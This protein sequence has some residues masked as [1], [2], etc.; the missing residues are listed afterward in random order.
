MQEITN[1][2]W[3]DP[4]CITTGRGPVMAR[5]SEPNDQFWTLWREHS[6]ALRNAGFSIG[7]FAGK[8]K[9]T[10]WE[11]DG[12]FNLP[13]IAAPVA[14]EVPELVLSPLKYPDG[15]LPYQLP[16]TQIIV[17][18][19]EEFNTALNASST[20]TGKTFMTLGAIRE[21]GRRALIICPKAIVGDWKDACKRMGVECAG[22][23]G[24]EWMK[25]GKTP[26]AK[27]TYKRVKKKVGKEFVLVDQKDQ[28]VWDVPDDCDLV[29][30]ECHRAANA[31]TIN[32]Q[33]VQDAVAAGYK[34][35]L[36]SATVADNPTK[37]KA[38]G[39]ALRLHKNSK[40]FLDWMKDHG[41]RKGRF[42]YEFQGGAR[43]LQSI[44]RSIFPMRGVRIRAEELGKAF[45][46][47]QIL[48]KA[49]DM[50]ESKAI[51]SVYAEM[52]DKCAEIEAREKDRSTRQASI[53]VEILRARQKVEFLKIPLM[54]SLTRD[55]HEEGNSIF[56][57]VNFRESLAELCK[58]L[59]TD[60]VIIGGQ[61]DEDRKKHI[62]RFQANESN[63]IIGII[64]A[65]R[66]GLNLHD[67]HGGRPRVSLISPTP[68]AFDLRQV[69]GR[70]W[71][72]GGKTPSLQR[73]LFARDTVEEDVCF[74]IATKLDQLDLIM[75]GD[76]SHGI[77]PNGYSEMR[78]QTD[79]ENE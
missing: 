11:R 66:E 61:K 7:K 16:A 39:Y 53:L 28:L 70:V 45:P 75:D 63:V 59:K 76:L 56:L 48:A 47:T 46:E 68:S 37:M 44:H 30:D 58:H 43:H 34:I 22:A 5:S 52:M 17:R 57:A 26:F 20:G 62:A 10:W 31:D 64:K 33:M 13:E 35:M 74:S 4:Q 27:W 25:T 78:P 15:L 21:R 14:E 32:S 51:A 9:L 24:W 36:L 3:S 79:S 50:E 23:Y 40:D 1:L 73:I 42:G 77:F 67:I 65:C 71:R 29:F 60:S 38:V 54:V 18:A 19:M 69:L 8:W 12:K 41:V 72:A 6:Q 49:Y 55:Y 2:K